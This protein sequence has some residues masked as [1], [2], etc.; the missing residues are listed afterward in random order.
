[1]R[2]LGTTGFL[3]PH[4][5]RHQEGALQD[6][7]HQDQE[8]QEGAHQDQEHQDQEHQEGER[9]ESEMGVEASLLGQATFAAGLSPQQGLEVYAA[10]SRAREGLSLVDECHLL[11]QLTPVFQPI[12]PS[13]LLY[14]P[15][16][17]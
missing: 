7:E 16:V 10:L 15:V 14:M 8:H 3:R 1:M 4:G 17:L 5:R 13:I 9:Q 11:F 12:T 6:Q 2:Y